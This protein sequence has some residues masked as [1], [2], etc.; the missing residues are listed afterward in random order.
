[1]NPQLSTAG[2]YARV[3]LRRARGRLRRLKRQILPSNTGHSQL[4]PTSVGGST[5]LLR[6]PLLGDVDRFAARLLAHTDELAEQHPQ[7]AGRPDRWSQEEALLTWTDRMLAERAEARR[8][9]RVVELLLLT[10]GEA[11]GELVGE[12]SARIDGGTSSADLTLWVDSRGVGGAS[13]QV[14]AERGMALFLLHIAASDRPP[15]R[16]FGEVPVLAEPAAAGE[17]DRGALLA[18]LGFHCEGRLIDSRLHRG[19]PASHDVWV[20][21]D[22][23]EFRRNLQANLDR[24]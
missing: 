18:V 6:P 19:R 14:V 23:A 11:L 13:S 2:R 24:S 10:A 3:R 16:Y 20:A 5:L 21:H 15:S 12:V 1:M 9:E 22:S 17:L 4:S 7:P 8:G